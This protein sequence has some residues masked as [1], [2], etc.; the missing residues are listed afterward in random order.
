M[1]KRETT[2]RAKMSFEQDCKKLLESKM[3]PEQLDEIR[4]M[5]NRP[6]FACEDVYRNNEDNLAVIWRDNPMNIKATK[7]DV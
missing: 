7:E 3:T 6:P 2:E 1:S 4:N 5:N